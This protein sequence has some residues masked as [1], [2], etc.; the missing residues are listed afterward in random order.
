MDAKK[1]IIVA[2][3]APTLDD[4]KQ[5]I[6]AFDGE[7]SCFKVGLEAMTAIGAPQV[8]AAVKQSGAE[9]FFDGKFHDIPNTVGEAAK[10]AS[11]LG[12]KM[13]NVHATTGKPAIQAAAQNKGNSLLL[14][15]TV[16][17]SLEESQCQHIYGRKS[18]DAVIQFASDAKEG[19]A[20]GIVCSPRELETLQANPNLR[21]LIKVTP[22]VRPL[23]ATTGDQKRTLTPSEALRAG[24]DYLVI[25]RPLTAPPAS[26]G[27]PREALA[28]VVDELKDTLK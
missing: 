22:G 19:G 11:R 15:V 26:V 20:D 10:A 18:L 9:I 8:V 5:L 13:F 27:S 21:S 16:L 12:V 7:I 3:D 4:L 24:A 2:L 23:W 14:A 1:K 6:G 25:G 17:T 28:R